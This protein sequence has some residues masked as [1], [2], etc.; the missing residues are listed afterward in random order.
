MSDLAPNH[1]AEFK[2]FGGVFG[3]LAALT[4]IPGRGRDARLAIDLA[5]LGED[6]RVLDIGCGPGSA[7]RLAADL[8]SRATGLD[9]AEP[10][11]SVA[12]MLTRLRRPSGEIE[13]V[14][15]GAEDMP[16]ADES[17]SVVWSIRS[18]HHWPD[19]AGGIG[20][21][22]RVLA[23]DGRL[24]VVE[25]RS[26]PGATGLSSHGWTDPQAD[27][28]AAMLVDAGFSTPVVTTHDSGRSGSISVSATI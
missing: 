24:V 5:G 16:L 20:E 27:S 7:V 12:R 1:H 14:C 26:K 22:R 2:Q 25:S 11:L 15:A 3:F 13:W 23:P 19:L 4:M 21:V 6:D 9:P 8:C 10:M 28:F 17:V 18:V